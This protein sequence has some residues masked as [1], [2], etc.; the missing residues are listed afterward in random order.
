MNA[1]IFRIPLLI[2]KT[3]EKKYQNSNLS[4]VKKYRIVNSVRLPLGTSMEMQA[5]SAILPAKKYNT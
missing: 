2:R 4:L 1:S 3:N 5:P